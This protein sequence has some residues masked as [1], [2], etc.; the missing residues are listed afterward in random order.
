MELYRYEDSELK[1][2]QES[3]VPFA[4]YQYIDGRV[5]TLALTKGF[6][7]LFKL[8]MEKAYEYMANDMY[9]D[10]YPEDVPY[11][12]KAAIEFASDGENYNILYRYNLDG[13]YRI[14]HAYGNRVVKEDGTKLAVIWYSDEGPYSARENG[15]NGEFNKVLSV[16]LGERDLYKKIKYDYI[17][18][19]PGMSYFFDL[20]EAGRKELLS[21]KKDV[22]IL[23]FDLSGMKKFNEQY[24]YTEGDKLI[25]LFSDLLVRHFG[26]NNCGHFSGDDFAAYMDANGLEQKLETFFDDCGAMNDGRNLP[27]RVG[28]YFDKIGTIPISVACERAKIAADTGK[29][30]HSSQVYYF[31]YSMVEAIEKQQYIMENLDKAIDEGWIEVYFQPIIRAANDKV[32]EE[33]CLARWNDPENGFLSPSDFIPI[34]EEK[35]II[36]KLDLHIVDKVIEKLKDQAANGLFIVPQT[37]NLSKEDFYACDMVE[38]IRKKVDASGLGRQYLIIEISEDSISSDIEFMKKQTERFRSLGFAVWMDDYGSGNASPTIL[39]NIHFD[40]VKIDIKFIEQI[41]KKDDFSG[42]IVLSEI[43]RMIMA[44]NM[45]AVAEGVETAEQVEFLKEIGC[46]KLQGEFYVRPVSLETIYERYRNGTQIG[47]ENPDEVEYYEALGRVNLYDFSTAKNDDDSLKNYFDTMPM[48]IYEVGDEEVKLLRSNKSHKEFA[49]HSMKR[50]EGL[51]KYSYSDY[52]ESAW[53]NALQA[54]KHCAKDGRRM[55]LDE[56]TPDGGIVQVFVRRIAVNPVTGVAAVAATVLSF[57]DN[58]NASSGLTYTHVA[59]AL[60]EDYLY[61]YYVDMDTDKF[62]EYGN[63]NEY[64][65][66]P[67]E[68]HGDDFFSFCKDRAYTLVNPDD[69]DNFLEMFTKANI[70]KSLKKDGVFNLAY[71]IPIDG[72]QTYVNLKALPIKTEGNH[73]IIGISNIDAQ[74]RQREEFERIKEEQLT[75]SRMAA[76][77]GDS[78]CIYVVDPATDKYKEYS[79]KEEYRALGIRKSGINFFESSIKS[80]AKRIYA[81]DF[82]MF[83]QSFTKDKVMNQIKENG[84]FSL[85]YRLMLRGTPTY[86]NLKAVLVEEKD[87]PQLVIGISNIDAQIKREQEYT[88]NLTAARDK[89]NIDALTGVKNKHAYVDFEL[90]INEMIEEDAT[91]EFAIVVFDLNGL[92]YI[93]DT[94]GHQAGDQFIKDGCAIICSIFK[95]SPVYRVGGDEFAVIVQGLDYDNIEALMSQVHDI[96]VKNNEEGKVVIA[97]GMARFSSN[98]RRVATVFERAD[99]RMYENKKMLKGIKD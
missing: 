19:L 23:I 55:I 96:N 24:G 76:L 59:R 88:H 99:A 3:C 93:N 81:D 39:Q 34:L 30:V 94:Y 71:R 31:D 97:A 51:S 21:E 14:I 22:A 12:E 79:S 83:S 47:F 87:G 69:L 42:K 66:L 11:L 91:P 68:Q 38:E 5:I 33:E 32:C 13:E 10:I 20:A 78:I 18:G 29:E 16:A 1:F 92:K 4:V 70:E 74:M 57:I 56:R 75:F 9:K 40:Q 77:S 8:P 90:R 53:G 89:A 27:V 67:I 25:S 86:V 65:D 43:V 84:L 46:T 95:H 98:D 15:R 50:I 82:D 64:G 28:I 61:L 6:C 72:K 36:Y 45:N 44:L 37:I 73:I 52:Q 49:R 62:V 80:G 58:K 2:M 85:N 26:N 48:A 60:S 7:D 41:E 17:T 54:M 63:D 35:S